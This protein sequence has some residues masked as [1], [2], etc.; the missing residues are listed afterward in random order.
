M[1]PRLSVVRQAAAEKV[2]VSIGG[3]TII[4]RSDSGTIEELYS[5]IDRASGFIGK[6]IQSGRS[7][8]ITHGNGPI[9]GNILIQNESASSLTPPMPLYICDADSEGGIGFL[10]QQVLY[11]RLHRVHNIKDVVTIVTQ[12][13]VDSEDPAFKNPEKPV[14]PFYS[15]EDAKRLIATRGWVMKEDSQRGFRRVVPSPLPRRVV[16]AGVIKRLAESGVVVIAAGGGGVP[17]VEDKEGLLRGVDAVID[18]DLATALLAKEALA[19]RFINLTQI[20]MVYLSFGKPG[21]KGIPRM[22]VSEARKHLEAGEFA[23]GSMGPKVQAAINFIE[24]GGKEAIITSPE[25]VEAAL[26]GRAG[27]RITR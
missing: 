16:E 22:N 2:I 24:G 17:V 26:D 8:I 18:K 11:N 14:G 19:E 20:D 3:N 10:I 25:A 15:E 5:N 1:E 4:R 21:Q 23:P 27:T 6:M 13:I 7:V 9:V 12:V